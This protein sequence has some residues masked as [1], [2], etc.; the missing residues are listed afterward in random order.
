MFFLL[1]TIALGYWLDFHKIIGVIYQNYPKNLSYKNQLIYIISFIIFSVVSNFKKKINEMNVKQVG[2]NKFIVSYEINGKKYKMVVVP[3][4]GP[5]DILQVLNKDSV[6]ITNKL[7]PYIGT[8]YNFIHNELLTP[9]FF[10]EE[11]IT[12]NLSDGNCLVFGK[13][14]TIVV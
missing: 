1:S 5:S 11:E 8:K 4:R 3:K 9:E 7:E 2:K 13:D 10:E 12:I 14:S 6:D